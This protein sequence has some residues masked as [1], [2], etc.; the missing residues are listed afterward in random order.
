[1]KEWTAASK[2]TRWER[3]RDRYRD[4]LRGFEKQR[5]NDQTSNTV[6]M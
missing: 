6:C 1:M 2:K 4:S 3:R 5:F